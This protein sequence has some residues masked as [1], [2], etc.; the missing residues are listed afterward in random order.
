MQLQQGIMLRLECSM[1][2]WWLHTKCVALCCCLLLLLVANLSS[3]AE[4]FVSLAAG[5]GTNT[6]NSKALLEPAQESIVES[7]IY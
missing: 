5:G 2:E 1:E 6:T 3:G 4:C 7:A